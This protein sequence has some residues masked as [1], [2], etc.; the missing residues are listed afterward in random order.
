M[1]AFPL[2][3]LFLLWL[4]NHKGEPFTQA[5]ITTYP[6]GIQA[7]GIVSELIV[8]Y[9]LDITGNRIVTGMGIIAVQIVCAS[10]LLVPNMSYAGSFFAFYASGSSYAVN[11]LMYQWANIIL[12]REGDDAK[13]GVIL[14]SM[15]GTGMILWTFWGIALY[16]ATDA[17]YWKKGSITIICVSVALVGVVF[18]VRWVSIFL[19]LLQA[20]SGR[21]NVIVRSMDTRR[22][23]RL[24]GILRPATGTGTDRLRLR[25]SL[26]GTRKPKRLGRRAECWSG[27]G[28]TRNLRR[29][30]AGV[31]WITHPAGIFDL[32][33]QSDADDMPVDASEKR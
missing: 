31:G 11:P 21:A 15:V 5:N 3:G 26:S 27:R 6:L 32:H 30:V 12:G 29:V 2:Q 14:A 8:A 19:C 22:E 23:A 9:F 20:V 13:R 18:L 4:K 16:P 10:V 24:S 25:K 28:E 33:L 7:V 1:Q 17:P